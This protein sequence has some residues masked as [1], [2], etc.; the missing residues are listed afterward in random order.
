MLARYQLPAFAGGRYRLVVDR[1]A[2]KRAE[3]GLYAADERC[4]LLASADVHPHDIPATVRRLVRQAD[5]AGPDG[6]PVAVAAQIA[7]LADRLTHIASPVAAGPAERAGVAAHVRDARLALR[8][9][10][11]RLA[12]GGPIAPGAVAEGGAS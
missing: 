10:A 4:R 3:V 8:L 9:L 2:P 1:V 11:E 6:G 12:E 7:E 5:A